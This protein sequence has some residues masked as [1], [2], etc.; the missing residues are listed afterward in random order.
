[1]VKHLTKYC[2]PFISTCII[3]SSPTMA[4]E[5]E[6][7]LKKMLGGALN[8]EV[9]HDSGNT[10]SIYSFYDKRPD[11]KTQA[12]KRAKMKA[13]RAEIDKKMTEPDKAIMAAIQK[14]HY[15]VSPSKIKKSMIM[16]PNVLRDIPQLQF[17]LF[18]IGDDKY[19]LEWFSV[20]KE[21]LIRFKAAGVLTSVRTREAFEKI[22]KLVKPLTL[23]PV[24]ADFIQE[25]FDV[26]Y[27]P[28][29]ITKKG[30][31]R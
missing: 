20:N 22:A 7:S 16:R 14:G 19:S 2:L 31:F 15:P 24:N 27:Y 6:V 12:E 13:L 5:N 11:I 1:M 21:E 10:V 29:L 26:T 30:V 8:A 18:V 4:F 28:A 9:I 23:M 3:F 17:N 25:E